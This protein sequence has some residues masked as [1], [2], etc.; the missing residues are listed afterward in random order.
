[1]STLSL[2]ELLL[3]KALSI[4]L[5]LPLTLSHDFEGTFVGVLLHHTLQF[6][7]V[8]IKLYHLVDSK[9]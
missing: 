3:E 9:N 2:S 8:S 5:T 7:R 1:M 4:G 6:E